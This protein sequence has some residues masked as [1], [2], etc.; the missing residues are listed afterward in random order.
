MRSLEK[1]QLTI[2]CRDDQE[3]LTNDKQDEKCAVKHFFLILTDIY[4]I[5]CYFF[6]VYL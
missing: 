6:F 1:Y 3:I 2:L 5:T 4:F